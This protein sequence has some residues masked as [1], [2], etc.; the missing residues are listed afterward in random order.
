MKRYLSGLIALTLAVGFTAFKI[1]T[2]V[3]K[4]FT[5]IGAVN[6]QDQI[7]DPHNWRSAVYHVQE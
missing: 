7:E 4:S 6:D 3:N 2:H 5:Y 1:S